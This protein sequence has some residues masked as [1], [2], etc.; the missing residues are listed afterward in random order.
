MSIKALAFVHLY[1]PHHNA[2]AEWMLHSIFKKMVEVYGWECR[3]VVGR[4]PVRN[5]HFQG[6]K[7]LS[8][9]KDQQDVL[10]EQCIWADVVF[11]HLD[12]TREAMQ[13][14][15]ELH[16]PLVHL[17]HNHLQLEYFGV[18][19]DKAAL[20]VFN[21]R[22]LQDKVQWGS[23]ST[24]MV[25]PVWLDDYATDPGEAITLI[26]MSVEKGVDVF[27]A[28]AEMFPNEQFLGVRGAYGDQAPEPKMHNL[29]I[30]SQTPNIKEEIYRRTKILLMP[31]RYES[32]GRVCVEAAASGIPTI[33]AST[34]GLL[35]TGIPIF[36]CN[37]DPVDLQAWR[38]AVER[39]L[40]QDTYET[41]GAQALSRARDLEVMSMQQLS[42][43]RSKVVRL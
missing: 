16:K 9:L 7:V 14:T 30:V 23:D 22:W 24:V 34:P 39:L 26:N 3:V 28:L 41:A 20:V 33:A 11:T 32:W 19:P 40:K 27:Y 43:L 29:T 10:R 25:P 1:P 12:F 35:E 31:S 2:G 13:L 36:Y 21:S 42:D 15:H 8:A 4:E 6:I 5:D 18:T 37:V 17:V 38:D